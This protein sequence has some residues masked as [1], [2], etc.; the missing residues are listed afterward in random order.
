ME[1]KTGSKGGIVR[2]DFRGRG[3]QELSSMSWKTVLT[4]RIFHVQY[5]LASVFRLFKAFLYEA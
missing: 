2:G 3:H 1:V 4:A 5:T